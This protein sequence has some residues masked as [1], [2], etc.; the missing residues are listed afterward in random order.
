MT[1]PCKSCKK[2][3]VLF[4]SPIIEKEEELYTKIY[5]PYQKTIDTNHTL[6]LTSK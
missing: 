3:V 2:K 4:T 5:H 6:F 1:V